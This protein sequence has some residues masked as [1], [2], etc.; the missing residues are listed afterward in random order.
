MRGKRCCGHRESGRQWEL[1]LLHSVETDLCMLGI[2]K[3]TKG[4]KV[5]WWV[6]IQACSSRNL[7]H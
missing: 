1:N 2:E 7:A 6:S 5:N 3:Y 4:E